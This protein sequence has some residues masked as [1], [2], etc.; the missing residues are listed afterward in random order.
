MDNFSQLGLS[1]D[2]LKALPELNIESPTEIQK[3]A[4]PLLLKENKDLIGL[5]QTGTGKTAAFGLPLLQKIDLNQKATQGIV[6]APTRE[7]GQQIATQLEHFSKYIKGLN[8]TVVYGGAAIVNQIKDLKRNP[9]IVVGTPGRLLDLINRKALRLGDIKYVVFDEADEMLSMGFQEDIDK[10]LSYCPENITTWLFSATMPREI[11]EI[12]DKYMTN[13]HEVSVSSGDKT[14]KN[15]DHQYAVINPHDKEEGLK[16][17][18]D[19]YPDMR[20]IIFCR[21]KAGAQKLAD[22]LYKKGFN[23]AALHG[24]LSQAQRDRVMK[25]FKAHGLQALVATDVAARG[26]DVN[27]L[28]HVFHHM[29]PDDN[30]YYTHRSGR[31]AR[32][33]KKGISI[34]L[35]AG[36]DIRK[37]PYLERMLNINFTKIDIP[38]AKDI[39]SNTVK[40]L[41][42]K[43]KEQKDTASKIDQDLLKYAFNQFEEFS[44]EDLIKKILS[45]ELTNMD[46]N[47]TRDLN[48]PQNNRDRKE[49]NRKES[50]GSEKGRSDRSTS[51]RRSNP[52]KER[53]F[54]NVGKMDDATKEDLVNLIT[55][56]VGIKSSE[57]SEITLL[58]KH[59]YFNVD[60]K[61]AKKVTTSFKGF[62]VNDRE[63]RVN[64]DE[65]G[66]RRSRSSSSPKSGRERSFGKK[67]N[68]P[69][70]RKQ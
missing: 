69:R 51:D 60:K 22:E 23:I 10:I 15:I 28:T 39:Q 30:T 9:Q 38:Q 11:R 35:V 13:P 66:G 3:Q 57:V 5:A 56:A 58:D 65:D 7:L 33:G 63:I 53:F 50:R 24:D 19:L 41:V 8:V 25:K 47:D 62:Y 59:A 40:S 45:K 52:D 14:N 48:A 54:I 29:L 37:I 70:K 64:K 67:D 4:I 2:I 34:A 26:I 43:I 31:T 18:L 1:E 36:K 12:V 20:G 16:R 46:D 44:K 61:V 32:A 27:D 21:T 49:R 6:V 68:R 55:D 17:F 42:D